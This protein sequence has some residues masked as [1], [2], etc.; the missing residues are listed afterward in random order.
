MNERMKDVLVNKRESR[1]D[2][3]SIEI[4]YERSKGTEEEWKV[5]I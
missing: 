2:V 3:K 1:E 4:E 5:R